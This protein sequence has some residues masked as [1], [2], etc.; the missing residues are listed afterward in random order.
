MN[1]PVI[2]R[3]RPLSAASFSLLYCLSLIVIAAGASE[4]KGDEKTRVAVPEPS[5]ESG[6]RFIFRLDIANGHI[7][8]VFIGCQDGATDGF[9]LRVDDMA[10]PPGIGGV[11]YTFLVSPDRKYNLY[12]DIRPFADTAQWLFYARI[13]QKPVRVSWNS[14]SLPKGWDLFCGKWDGQS[15]TVESII[16]CRQEKSVEAAKTGFFRFWIVR[17]NE[18]DTHGAGK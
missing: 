1:R 16:D 5:R 11:G 13:G 3:R 15:E 12:K 6:N 7:G 9:D 18:T 17:Q 4:K 2:R 8:H 14:A 10:P